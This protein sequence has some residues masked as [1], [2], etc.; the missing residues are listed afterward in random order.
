MD[1]QNRKPEEV[2]AL[3]GDEEELSYSGYAE[4]TSVRK[5]I[6]AA[7]FTGDEEDS[8][9]SG[10]HFGG[11]SDDAEDEDKHFSTV[12]AMGEAAHTGDFIVEEFSPKV[13]AKGLHRL[14]HIPEEV[15]LYVLSTIYIIVGALCVT[16]TDYMI[17]ALPY[18]IGVLVAVVGIIRFIYA[19][20]Q[21]EYVHTH[22]NKTASSLILMGVAV[23]IL[24]DFEWAS[25][26][27]PTIWGLLG[28]FEAAH[29]FNH[30]FSRIARHMRWWYYIGKGVVELVLAFL[31]LYDPL[32]HL[33]VHIIIFGVQIIFRGITAI[34]ALKERLARR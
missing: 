30:G 32:G 33:G 11:E 16:I 13:N 29:A 10:Y 34:P 17:T 8:Y 19:V 5:V 22:S 6:H 9:Y 18:I 24:I 31:L 14:L 7:Y 3:T 27:I 25:R 28:L 4:G 23:V 15:V 26:F 21:K 2:N 1:N 12:E 20:I